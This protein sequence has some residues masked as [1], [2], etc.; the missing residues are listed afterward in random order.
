ML[1]MVLFMIKIPPIR[2]KI[3]KR[4]PNFDLLINIRYTR[5]EFK[6]LAEELRQ[7]YKQND[8]Q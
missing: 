2:Y 5:K 8:K 6:K 3:R 4:K 1:M 7:K